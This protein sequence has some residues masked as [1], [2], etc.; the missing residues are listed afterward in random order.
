VPDCGRVVDVLVKRHLRT[1]VRSYHTAYC[2]T[3]RAG[4][5]RIRSLSNERVGLRLPYL[6]AVRPPTAWRGVLSRRGLRAT[7]AQHLRRESRRHRRPLRARGRAPSRITSTSWRRSSP[8]SSRVGGRNG[9]RTETSTRAW[10]EPRGRACS[11][12]VR[13]QAVRGR[14][15]LGGAVRDRLTRADGN[16]RWGSSGREE[17]RANR[18]RRRGREDPWTSRG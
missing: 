5:G 14:T 7:R 1:R 4:G 12:C 9:G 6:D 10:F 17:V 16:P 11:P 2:L 15:L 13:P 8:R 18:R 3:T